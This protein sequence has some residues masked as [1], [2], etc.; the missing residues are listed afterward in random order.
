MSEAGTVIT[1]DFPFSRTGAEEP[2]RVPADDLAVRRWY[3]KHD[4]GRELTRAELERLAADLAAHREL[5]EHLVV[6]SVDERYY[7]RLHRDRFTEIWL[8]CWCP[9]QDTGFHDHDGS[10]GGVA[11]VHGAIRETLLGACGERPE[12]VYVE[13]EAFSFGASH[14]HDVQYEG[15]DPAAS[16]HAYSP[17][18]GEMGFYDVADDGTLRRR[19]GDHR[20][21]FC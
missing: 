2:V 18:L 13:G 7:V 10:R 14:I 8:I 5:W 15:G 17:P 19:R 16:L 9:S 3:R 20:E 12:V 21:E 4:R 6:R 1:G 11:V